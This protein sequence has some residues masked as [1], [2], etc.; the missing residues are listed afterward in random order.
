MLKVKTTMA[1]S[2]IGGAMLAVSTGAAEHANGL[3][4][5]TADELMQRVRSVYAD[6]RSYADTGTVAL[7]YGTSSI[8]RHR[9]ATSFIRAPRHFL[10]DFTK[11]TGDRYV[12]WGNPD[13]FHTWWKTTNQRFDYPNPSNVPAVSRRPL[14][15]LHDIGRGH[16][17]RRWPAVSSNL[18]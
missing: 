12:V 6:L 9:F 15:Q 10:L 11:S 16:R 7:E 14:H 8:D 1:L 2:M 3:Q 5:A 13:A 17:D 4:A 18:R